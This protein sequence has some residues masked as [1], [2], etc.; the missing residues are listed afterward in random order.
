MAR[1]ITF[2][3]QFPKNHIR[4]GDNT[5]FLTLI[6]ENIKV[7]TI[8]AGNRWKV[9]DLFSPRCWSGM[10]YRSKQI[11]ILDDLNDTLEVRKVYKFTA[12]KGKFY[13]NDYILSTPELQILASRDGLTLIDFMS[14]MGDT[15]EGQVICW[16]EVD[17]KP[18][19]FTLEIMKMMANE[20]NRSWRDNLIKQYKQGLR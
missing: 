12:N 19:S 9:G 4:E 2:S 13:L 16:R 11:P 8:R 10:P 7:H 1:V 5:H 18:E 3:R 6:L 17:Y 14:W 20:S 15:F